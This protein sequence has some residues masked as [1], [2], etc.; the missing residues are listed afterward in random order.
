MRKRQP[1]GP[2]HIVSVKGISSR[3]A[4]VTGQSLSDVYR[5]TRDGA[6]SAAVVA[7]DE[8]CGEAPGPRPAGSAASGEHPASTRRA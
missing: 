3:L 1:A 5:L 7:D 2:S 4:R 6:S 8:T